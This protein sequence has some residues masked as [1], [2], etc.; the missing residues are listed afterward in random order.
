MRLFRAHGL[1]NDYLVLADAA[2]VALDPALVRA[3]CDRHEGVGSDGVLE[4]ASPR[5]GADYGL[6]I[7]NPDGSEAEKSGNGLRIFALW[8]VRDRGAAPSFRVWTPGGVVACHVEGE[9]VR[10]AMGRAEVSPPRALCG[11]EAHPVDVGNPHHVVLGH[12]E[13]WRALGARMERAVEGRTNVQFV[14]VDGE[15]ALRVK[16]WERG[17]GETRS[18]G[19]SACAT[20]AVGVKLGLVRSPVR[21]RM[22]GGELTVAVGAG[23]DVELEGP[24][25][26]IGEVTVDDGWLRRRTA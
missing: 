25:E 19:S 5:E 18:S 7:H 16:V 22:D 2:G 3:I 14:E 15:D 1:G 17:A 24:V 20:A 12:R 9:R 6:R 8:L 23:G 13:D 11:V 10:V 4:P 21:V 26:A